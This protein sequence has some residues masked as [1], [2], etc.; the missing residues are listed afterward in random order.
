M[1]K[2]S[3]KIESES[4]NKPL[5]RISGIFWG[6]F[7]ENIESQMDLSKSQFQ[8]GFFGDFYKVPQILC[9]EK[10]DLG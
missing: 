7:S 4:Q 10:M 6:L 5:S 9:D 3:N 2:V 1:H 8:E